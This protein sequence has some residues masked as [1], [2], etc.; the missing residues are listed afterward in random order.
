MRVLTLFEHESRRCELQPRQIALLEQL[1]QRLAKKVLEPVYRSG[2][3]GLKANQY[4][5][6]VRV[7]PMTI[8]I[9]PKIFRSAETAAR[10]KLASEATANLLHMLAYAGL[11][12]VNES[13]VADLLNQ[14]SDWFEILTYLFAYH[15]REEWRRGPARN[16]QTFEDELPILKGKWLL[17]IQFRRPDRAHRFAVAYDEFTVDILLNR[18]FRFVVERL[19]RLSRSPTNAKLLAD[20]RGLLDEVTL[21]PVITVT[22][23]S[24]VSLNR[25]TSRYAPLLNMARLFLEQ[26]AL[27]TASG[28]TSLF[29]FV[30]DMNAV[31]EGFVAG[32]LRRHRSLAIPPE[33]QACEIAVQSQG[34]QLHLATSSGKRFFRLKPDLLFRKGDTA[35]LI[36]DTKYKLLDPSD[37]KLGISEADFYQM[38]AYARRYDCPRVMLLY[39]QTSNWPISVRQSFLLDGTSNQQVFAMTVD[40]RRDLRQRA[41]QEALAAELSSV[42]SQR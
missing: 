5:G 1:Q 31:F 23:V 13:E 14:E 32:F 30:F 17:N 42:L 34:R 12:Q 36:V 37:R 7:G 24:Q 3:W 38:F 2:P 25:L 19:S 6:V 9:L 8:Q 41:G 4:V 35:E 39:P 10:E 20:L 29:A 33:L 18:I 28:D 15:L 22:D 26:G 11:I 21:L 27:Q 16:Y 40:I